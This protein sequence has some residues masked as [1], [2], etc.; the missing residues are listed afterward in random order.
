M[1]LGQNT[2]PGG[3]SYLDFKEL[4]HRADGP[5][6]IFARVHE[7]K[8]VEKNTKRSERGPVLPVV[9]D[10]FIATGPDAGQLHPMEEIIGAPTAALRGVR[11]P[12]N[13]N[14][15]AILEPVNETGVAWPFVVSVGLNAGSEFVKFDTPK[16]AHLERAEELYAQFG[17]D[18]L[19][20]GQPVAGGANVP[21]Q[22]GSGEDK[23][24]VGAGTGATRKRPWD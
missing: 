12:S 9:A 23:E 20:K 13:K 4:V 15:W 5:V 14:D 18:E 17:D 21:A 24:P 7:F 11:N 19:W 2:N 6:F 1:P 10:I 3:G 22:G 16:G 8:P